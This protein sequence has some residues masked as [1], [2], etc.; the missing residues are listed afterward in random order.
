MNKKSPAILNQTETDAKS[1]K[2]THWN[3]FENTS[4]Y[5][6]RNPKS[7]LNLFGTSVLFLASELCTQLC[8]W[9][10]FCATVFDSMKS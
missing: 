3:T 4:W 1:N 5:V 10:N 9:S 8:I 2:R 7:L 6:Q